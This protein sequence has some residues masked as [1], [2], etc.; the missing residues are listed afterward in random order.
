[1]SWHK[2]NAVD[3]F[4]ESKCND[5]A[6]DKIKWNNKNKNKITVHLLIV[7]DHIQRILR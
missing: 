5:S 7:G 2:G 1:M 3:G 4:D 6:S